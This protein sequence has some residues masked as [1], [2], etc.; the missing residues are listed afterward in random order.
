MRWA[1][2]LAFLFFGI[3]TFDTGSIKWALLGISFYSTPLIL[4]FSKSQDIHIYSLWIGVFLILQTFLTNFLIDRD[5]KT[6]PPNMREVI[7]IK[8]GVPGVSGKQLITTD[9]KGFR[10]TKTIDYTD[11]KPYRIFAIGGST[12]E[13]LFLDDKS[14]WTHLLQ[15]NLSKENKLDVEVINTGV[16]GLRANNHLSTLREIINLN[17]DLV[18]FLV[19]INDWN[20]HI[21]QNFNKNYDVTV[22][23]FSRENLLFSQSLLGKFIKG[24][25][26][27]ASTLSKDKK[28][29]ERDEF[30]D[31]FIRGSLDRSDVFSFT[32][33]S[34]ANEYVDTLSEISLLCKKQKI[35]CM[36]ITQP[37]G[38]Q[39][40]AT[41]DFKKDFWMTPPNQNYT[42]DFGSMVRLA[43]LY[44][45]FLIKFAKDKNHFI[46]DPASK[47][48]PTVMTF[49][50]DCHF[51]LT[52]A[53]NMGAIVTSCVSQIIDK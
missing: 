21:A 48:P 38:Y 49:Q 24:A 44:N 39:E 4:Q 31:Y 1:F 18:L 16:S 11:D 42:V 5:Y 37:T 7:N 17:P 23:K 14:T 10:T 19:G 32:P 26:R 25:F 3:F 9:F 20:R 22:G 46:C 43:S 33:G 45:S 28:T 34:V 30:G 40:G 41:E 12:T 53:K 29:P 8:S 35:K 27:Y 15:Q 2:S 6:L 52:G 50:D 51:S 47:L 36:F 13:Q